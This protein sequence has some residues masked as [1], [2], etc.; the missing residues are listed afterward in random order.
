MLDGIRKVHLIGIGG[1]GMRAIANILILKGFDVSGSDVKESDVINTFRDMGATIHI[2][3]DASYVN[4]VD[5]VVRSTAI[6]EDN[7]EIV[8]AKEQGIAILHRSDIVK[9]VLDVTNGI[10]VAGAH[11]KTSTTSM[12]GQILVEGC[13]DPTVIIGGEVDY[14]KG[15]SCLGK[16]KYSVV[17]ADESDGSFLKLKSHTIV[18]TNIEDDHMDYY[19]NM[20]NLLHAFCEF[21]ENLPMDG[22]AVVCGDNDHIQYV[23]TKVKRNFVTYGLEESNDYVAKNIH[24]EDSSLVYDIFH[25]GS[26]LGRIRLRVP[27]NHNVLNSLAAFIVAYEACELPVATIAKGLGKFVGAKRRFETKGHVAGV[28]VV[29]DYA[30]HPTEIKAT[31]KAAKELEKHRV[32][33]VFQPHR[34]SR[35]FLLKNEFATAFTS[36]DEIYMTNIYSSGEDPIS[37]IDG[38]T[39]PTAIESAT[40]HHVNYVDDVNDLPQVLAKV[41][42]PNDLVITMGAGSINQYGPKLLALLEEGL[43]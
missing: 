12:I 20:D 26:N 22:K 2:G 34:Y 42:R 41:V 3:H 21:V 36:A 14:L 39:I 33:C 43:Q 30:H 35:T 17:E 40:G 31:L 9:A 11:G 6:R 27:G 28:W 18:I 13:L 15:S 29:D 24:Y 37:G 38:Q 8:A 5:A 23:M 7:P 1:S 16:G 25:K 19:K 4:G 32:I 10:A